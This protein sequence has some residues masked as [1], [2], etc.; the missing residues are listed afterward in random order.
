MSDADCHTSGRVCE[1]V[2]YGRIST[3]EPGASHRAAAGKND[4]TGP[5]AV[6]A[7]GL[8]S[9][10]TTQ[11]AASAAARMRAPSRPVSR[12]QPAPTASRPP[13]DSATTTA[14]RSGSAEPKTG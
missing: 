2:G 13:A 10:G 8:G 9:S 3:V 11:A 1:P 7:Y 6:A 5:V 4:G 14:N 12:N